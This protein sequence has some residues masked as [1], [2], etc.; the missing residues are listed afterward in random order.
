M[1]AAR[2][3]LDA[4]EK[5]IRAFD[6]ARFEVAEAAT[7]RDRDEAHPILMVRSRVDAERTLLVLAG[8]HG[9]ERAG[10]LAVPFLLEAWSSSLRGAHE[11][12][13]LVVMTPVNPFGAAANR[14][15]NAQ[16]RDIN[17]DFLRFVTPE[18]RAVRAV[19]D[20]VNPNFVVSLHE[21][22]QRG[23]FMFTNRY[24]GAPLA[25]ALCDAL[26]AGGTV[27]AT[28]DYFGRSLRPAGCAPATAV[29]RAVWKFG[30]SALGVQATITYSEGRSVP[31][32]VLESSSR[33]TDEAAR[34]RPHVDLVLA[35]AKRL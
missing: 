26:A 9:D 35:V 32:I 14:R 27:L 22:P 34:I 25:I 20:E 19:F 16:R 12:V 2:F 31:E 3:D 28:R 33:T 10:I 13:R 30:A 15:T 4:Y 18:A 8:V 29:T 1:K 24:V 6:G 5:R 23:T 11:N 7:I 21:G 17:R